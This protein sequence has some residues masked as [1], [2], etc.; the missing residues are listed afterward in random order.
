[1]MNKDKLRARQEEMKARLKQPK[2]KPPVKAKEPKVSEPY[3]PPQ[4]VNKT[5]RK[6]N[7]PPAPKADETQMRSEYLRVRGDHYENRRD[8][9][10]NDLIIRMKHGTTVI[11]RDD[12]WVLGE[13]VWCVDFSENKKYVRGKLRSTGKLVLLHRLLTDA[14]PH[15][16]VDHKDRDGLN[17]RR[18]NLRICT[19]LQNNQYRM[20]TSKKFAYKGLKH[21]PTNIHRP[22]EA[23]LKKKYLGCYATPE[24]AA[25]AYDKAAIEEYG[26]FAQ[27]NFPTTPNIA[28]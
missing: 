2:A 15:T 8:E 23:Y 9:V 18:S 12:E 6:Y 10:G 3:S 16:L 26:E 25:R 14:P 11:D 1:M 22:W 4:P 21:R 19:K 20:G 7:R 27:L 17:N 28:A 24:E 5:K 13:A